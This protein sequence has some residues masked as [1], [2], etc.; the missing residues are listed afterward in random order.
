MG[1]QTAISWTK[2]M[3]ASAN[4]AVHLEVRAGIRPHANTLPCTN[5]GHVYSPGERRH[6]WDHYLG[7]DRENWFSVVVLCTRCHHAKGAKATQTH[8]IRGHLFDRANT[9][10]NSNGTRRCIA[11]QKIRSSARAKNQK[12]A[13]HMRGL[14]N[15]W[16]SRKELSNG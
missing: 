12:V 15:R 1:E 9:H 10:I 5:C 8:C 3:K 2:A 6:E 7:Y 4:Q 14:R 11:C 16:S 13:R